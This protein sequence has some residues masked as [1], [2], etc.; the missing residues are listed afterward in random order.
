M[1]PA[2]VDPPPLSA[3]EVTQSRA[4]S[5]EIAAVR[6]MVPD[7]RPARLPRRS[8]VSQPAWERFILHVRVLGNARHAAALCDG[9]RSVDPYLTEMRRDPLRQREFE[10]AVAFAEARIMR[11]LIRRGIE[12]YDEPHFHQS[13]IVAWVKKYDP[14]LALAVASHIAKVIERRQDSTVTVHNADAEADTVFRLTWEQVQRMPE[15]LRRQHLV[16]L[17]EHLRSEQATLAGD[18]PAIEDAE[19]DGV[20]VIEAD[21]IQ[22]PFSLDELAQVNM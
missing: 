7:G 4:T 14:K 9:G 22:D 12:G 13:E 15:S 11:E 19:L 3:E 2:M 17:L 20:S 5:R 21:E 8:S 6:A 10:S 16:P 18:A 1:K